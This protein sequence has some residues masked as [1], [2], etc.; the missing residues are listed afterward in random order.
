MEFLIKN[1]SQQ[2]DQFIS[3]GFLEKRV[4]AVYKCTPQFV[5]KLIAVIENWNIK[6]GYTLSAHHKMMQVHST[7]ICKLMQVCNQTN[8]KKLKTCINLHCAQKLHSISVCCDVCYFCQIPSQSHCWRY[9][10][11]SDCAVG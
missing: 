9:L 5:R 8:K 1:N 2:S 7:C 6:F 11:R 3:M 10:L 4:N